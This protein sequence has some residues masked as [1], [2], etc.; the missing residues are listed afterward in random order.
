MRRCTTPSRGDADAGLEV[1]DASAQGSLVHHDGPPDPAQRYVDSDGTSE[2]RSSCAPTTR[3]AGADRRARHSRRAELLIARAGPASSSGA[4]PYHLERG[5]DPGAAAAWLIDGQNQAFREG[6]YDAA[7]DLGRRGRVLC[8]CGVRRADAQLPDEA[9]HRRAHVPRPLRRRHRVIDEHRLTTTEV[10]EQMNDAYMLA[11]IYTRHLPRGA[12]GPGSRAGVG[13]HGP[14]ARPRARR[15]RRST[16]S[17]P[18]SCRTLAP[19]SSCTAETST[20]ARLVNEAIR[21]ADE[22]LTADDHQL[23]RTVLMN[24]RARCCSAEGL[25]RRAARVRRVLRRDPS[26]TSRTSTAPSCTRPRGDLA[27]RSRDLDRA[28]ELSIAFTD[29]YYNRPTSGWSWA[30]SSWRS[31]TS[32]RARHRSRLR[33]RAAQPRRPAHRA[34]DLDAAAADLT[35]GLALSPASANFW[36]ARGLLRSEQGAEDEALAA[37]APPSDL[38]PDL[39]EVY[40]NRAVLHFSAGRTAAPPPTSTEAIARSDTVVPRVN[41]GDRPQLGDAEARRRGPRRR[42]WDGRRGRRGRAVPARPEPARPRPPRRRRARLG[43]PPPGPAETGEPSRI[44]P[45]SDRRAG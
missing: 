42:A 27:R 40:G 9:G 34:G 1:V 19:S 22:H 23:H 8:R 10:P 18:P 44:S 4:I 14:R 15:R 30:T 45:L 5:E 11:M 39:V 37:S 31:P 3:C 7:L 25:R 38:D 35:R 24:N 16:R 43:R 12:A 13:Q 6:F 29:A 26:T 21:I 36:S 33:R 17:S 2:T 41:R 20:V 32:T 28:V